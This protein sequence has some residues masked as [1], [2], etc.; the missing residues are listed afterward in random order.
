M[1]KIA[2]VPIPT[3]CDLNEFFVAHKTELKTICSW[4]EN[5]K[6]IV[7]GRYGTNKAALRKI[8]EGLK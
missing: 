1:A 7:L 5:D 8:L 2:H 3:D 4:V 6:Y